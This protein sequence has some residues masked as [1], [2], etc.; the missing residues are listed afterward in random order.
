MKIP[1]FKF[2]IAGVLPFI[3]VWL[4]Q[5]EAVLL[6]VGQPLTTAQ[7]RDAQQVGVCYPER[8]RLVVSEEIPIPKGGVWAV[9][10]YLYRLICPRSIGFALGYGIYIQSQYQNS[11]SVL[12]HELVHI[13][14]HERFEDFGAFIKEYL[15]EVLE[16][17][18]RHAP[19]EEEAR[20]IEEALCVAKLS[21]RLKQ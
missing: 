15:S 3:E 5:Q 19:L 8:I 11:R 7:L 20:L 13:A 16:F 1:N 12:V 17:G 21:N 14:Q 2:L 10:I 4:R 9:G 6:Q 18:Y